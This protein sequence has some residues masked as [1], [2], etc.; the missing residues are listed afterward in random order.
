MKNY[1]TYLFVLGS[2]LPI[3]LLRDFTPSNELRYLSIADEAIRN[4][5]LFAFTNH[6]IPYAD[7]P[8]LYLWIVML[9]KV[10]FGKHCMLFLSLFSL[11]P[12]FVT[13]HVFDK[14]V[15]PYLKDG[16]RNMGQMMLL[17]CG[18]FLGMGV[19]LR[20]DMLMCMFIVLSLYTFYKML[21][22]EGNQKLNSFLFP[23][24]VFLAIFSK[25][26]VGIMVPL[27]SIIVFLAITGR[28]RTLGRY[29]GWKTWGILIALCA[30]WFGLVY[31]DGGQAYLDNLL[32]HQTIDRAV[33]SFHHKRPFYYYL[34]SVWYSIFPWS[35]LVIGVVCVGIYRKLIYTD[36]QKLFLTV[37]VVTFVMLSVISSK[38]QVYLLPAFPFMVYLAL[39]LL[40]EFKWNRWIAF[41]LA[42]PAV[43]FAL[44][45]PAL[46]VADRM[47]LAGQYASHLIYIGAGLLMLVALYSLYQLYR[48][49][50]IRAFVAVIFYGFFEVCF[51]VGWSLPELNVDM[52]YARL[53]E[54]TLEV[55]QEND[56][57]EYYVWKISR[58]ENMD[59]Y[60][61]KDIQ[62][63]S[64]E[65][66]DSVAGLEG[67]LMTQTRYLDKLPDAM[68]SMEKTEIGK[69]SIIVLK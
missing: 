68:Q 12:A 62:Q 33:D 47:G 69:Y 60:L 19:V 1:K 22:G 64:A 43:A 46:I 23:V 42:V 40:P 3:L 25:G 18:L 61:G 53:C 65:Q 54:K 39:L 63:V 58:P 28:I 4:G 67:L 14:W 50:D 35:L 38:L 16:Y 11:I 10:L 15:T 2:L 56:T 66:L 55:G 6:G 7:K 59:V 45:F 36:L 9:G 34:V 20:M 31:W 49:K 44:I 51:V 37:V 27:F 41:S 24:Y 13:V 29:W 21:R 52:G 17:S 48:K 57:D 32:F 8:P 5:N 30:L 26:P